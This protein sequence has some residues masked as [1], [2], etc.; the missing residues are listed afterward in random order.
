MTPR[1]KVNLEQ[2]NKVLAEGTYW[3]TT[4]VHVKYFLQNEAGMCFYNTEHKVLQFLLYQ[5][6]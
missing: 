6:W 3:V 5:K 4:N 1:L 2:T